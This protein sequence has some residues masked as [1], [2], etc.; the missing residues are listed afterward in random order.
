MTGTC[1]YLLVG[2]RSKCGECGVDLFRNT[3]FITKLITLGV[4]FSPD[5]KIPVQT[6]RKLVSDR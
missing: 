1:L 2:T 3:Y 4:V 5:V 6:G